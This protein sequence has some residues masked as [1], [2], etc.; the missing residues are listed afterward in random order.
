VTKELIVCFFFLVI[1]ISILGRNW[2]TCDS[3]AFIIT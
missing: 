2:W 3:Y 1:Y